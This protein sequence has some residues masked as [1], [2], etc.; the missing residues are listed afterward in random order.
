MPGRALPKTQTPFRLYGWKG[1]FAR[2]P[3]RSAA[4]Q[5]GAASKKSLC[6]TSGKL[7]KDLGKDKSSLVGLFIPA[8]YLSIVTLYQVNQL[9]YETQLAAV[10]S[11]GTFLATR[12]QAENEAVNLYELLSLRSFSSSKGLKDYAVSVRL[13]DWLGEQ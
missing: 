1:V 2:L 3:I 7:K 13:P 11:N 5:A 10:F 12:W 6:V 4:F 8:P 9:P